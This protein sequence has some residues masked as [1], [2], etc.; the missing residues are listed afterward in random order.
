MPNNGMGFDL[1]EKKVFNYEGP[2]RSVLLETQQLWAIEKMGN[3]KEKKKP[4]NFRMNNSR[5]F[6]RLTLEAFNMSRTLV[7]WAPSVANACKTW[8][9]TIKQKNKE[10]QNFLQ[11]AS[12][13]FL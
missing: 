6:S 12:P 10:N 2:E 8:I 13:F 3:R 9:S 11:K 4:K 1:S 5:T 7:Q